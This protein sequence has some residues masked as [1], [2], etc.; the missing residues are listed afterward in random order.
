MKTYKIDFYP[1]NK[2]LLIQGLKT[3]TLRSD[4]QAKKIGMTTGEV[5]LCYISSKL[6]KVIYLGKVHINDIGDYD[7]VWKSEG[8]DHTNGPK[9]DQ[10]YKFL[11]GEIK[12]HYYIF[13]R[14]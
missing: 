14:I 3:S 2:K 12:L 6:Y 9:F 13:E 5:G 4:S 8:F 7:K 10:T 11:N 1:D